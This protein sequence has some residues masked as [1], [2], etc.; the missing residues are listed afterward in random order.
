MQIW[1]RGR[2]QAGL[3]LASAR[4]AKVLRV[5]SLLRVEQNPSSDESYRL[6]GYEWLEVLWV[7]PWALAIPDAEW[8]AW[9]DRKIAV[10][11]VCMTEMGVTRIGADDFWTA[12]EEY[13]EYVAAEGRV[14]GIAAAAN[15]GERRRL[16]CPRW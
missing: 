9:C 16:H 11:Y 8:G 12:L 1:R 4:Q 15:C 14:G 3:E 2:C 5:A 13:E 6:L 7:E 10:Q